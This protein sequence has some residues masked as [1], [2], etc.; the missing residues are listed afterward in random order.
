MPE[1]RFEI[2]FDEDAWKE[3]E[4][5]DGSLRNIVDKYLERL[6]YRADEIGKNLENY[7]STK[8]AGCKELKLKKYGIRI[9]FRITD[10]HVDILRIVYVLTIESRSKDFVFKIADKRYRF[11]KGLSADRIKEFL[12]NKKKYKKTKK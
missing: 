7:V 3:Y 8:L 6:E 5:L 10:I 9:V 4:S 2:R 12:D 11:F 1:Q